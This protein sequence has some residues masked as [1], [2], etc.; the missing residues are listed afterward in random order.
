MCFISDP[1]L[2]DQLPQNFPDLA[3]P[4]MKLLVNSEMVTVKAA[5]RIKK[6]VGTGDDMLFIL[7][8]L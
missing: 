8:A 4:L 6:P 3:H 1:K 2:Y 5:E 7:F